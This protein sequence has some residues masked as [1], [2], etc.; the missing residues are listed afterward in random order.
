MPPSTTSDQS[1]RQ[2][3]TLLAATSQIAAAT[4]V[5]KVSTRTGFPVQAFD[6]RTVDAEAEAAGEENPVADVDLE[7]AGVPDRPGR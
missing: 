7:I 3:L 6:E 1:V 4:R 2:S 5:Q